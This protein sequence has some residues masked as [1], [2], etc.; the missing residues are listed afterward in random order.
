MALAIFDLDN[1]LIAGDSDHAWGEFLVERKLVDGDAFAR[2]NDQFY[3]DYKRGQLD[4]HAYL[5]FAL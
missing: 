1:T 5:A 2:A 3:E 4:I